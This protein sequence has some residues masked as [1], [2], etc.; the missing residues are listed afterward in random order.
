MT[1]SV[2]TE[3]PIATSK[4]SGAWLLLAHTAVV[5]AVAPPPFFWPRASR[6]APQRWS[7]HSAALAPSD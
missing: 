6:Y 7:L 5:G 2:M 4:R 1:H 3:T